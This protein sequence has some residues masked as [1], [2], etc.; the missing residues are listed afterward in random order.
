MQFHD[1]VKE[2]DGGTPTFWMDTK[3]HFILKVMS[4]EVLSSV[5]AAVTSPPVVLVI[6]SL[7]LLSLRHQLLSLQFTS[8]G[9]NR[10]HSM[11]LITDVPQSSLCVRE[12][13]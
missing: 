2:I 13:V 6:G 4:Q 9:K 11:F 5:T 10:T 7:R 1:I 3:D 8:G 12:S